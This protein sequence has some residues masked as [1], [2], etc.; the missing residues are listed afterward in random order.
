M[1]NKQWEGE[2]WNCAVRYALGRRTYI[3]V[4]VSDFMIDSIGS[5]DK[6]TKE[7]M[8]RDIEECEDLEMDCDEENWDKLL[9]KLKENL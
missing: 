6:R 3:T 1:K 2:I 9:K 7:V 8:I 5:M 4:V